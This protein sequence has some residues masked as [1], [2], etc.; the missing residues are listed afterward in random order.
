MG[1]TL[2]LHPGAVE[3][4]TELDFVES[5]AFLCGKEFRDICVCWERWIEDALEMAS[6]LP[7]SLSVQTNY[8][9]RQSQSGLPCHFDFQAF[10]LCPIEL[11]L[12]EID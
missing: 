1:L 12:P 10:D 11:I 3:G 8:I 6:V 2:G 9:A 4:R 7:S 5:S